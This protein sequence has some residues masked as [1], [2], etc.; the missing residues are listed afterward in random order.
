MT[1]PDDFT[2]TLKW[3]IATAGERAR[4]NGWNGP[5]ADYRLTQDDY[6]S[7]VVEIGTT[8]TRR[9][10]REAGVVDVAAAYALEDHLGSTVVTE[11]EP[12]VGASAS[13][14]DDTGNYRALI[15]SV[16]A[17]LSATVLWSRG[18]ATYERAFDIATVIGVIW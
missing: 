10:W 9:Q 3:H 14:S 18:E 11:E 13:W 16:L 12:F 15:L 7:I 6:D 1:L 8:P 5:D 2:A 4:A 17:T